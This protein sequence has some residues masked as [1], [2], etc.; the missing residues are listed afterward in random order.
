VKSLFRE[1]GRGGKG[2]LGRNA[3]LSRALRLVFGTFTAKPM[4]L[5]KKSDQ[6]RKSVIFPYD[7]MPLLLSNV[8][9]D[10]SKFDGPIET[11]RNPEMR[12]IRIW[13]ACY[14]RKTQVMHRRLAVDSANVAGLLDLFDQ[15]NHSFERRSAGNTLLIEGPD[16]LPRFDHCPNPNRE[17]P[18]VPTLT[19]RAPDARPGRRTGRGRR[20]NP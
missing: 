18:F 3:L 4:Q 6:P 1:I 8:G 7:T 20:C 19:P 13:G 5:I 17:E 14:L 11:R 16:I 9:V 2:F 10:V 15:P 12:T